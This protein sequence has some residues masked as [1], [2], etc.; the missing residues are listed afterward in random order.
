MLFEGLYNYM[1]LDLRKKKLEKLVDLASY[2]APA[3]VSLV[4][5]VTLL[6]FMSLYLMFLFPILEFRWFMMI[7]QL[8]EY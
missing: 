2:T 5:A 1:K 8:S 3:L 4:V 7:N 6:Q